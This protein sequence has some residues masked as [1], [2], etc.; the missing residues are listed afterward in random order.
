MWFDQSLVRAIRDAFPEWMAFFWALLSMLGSVWFVA[1]VVVLAFWFCDRHR[2]LSWVV[3]VLGGYAIMIGTKSYANIGRPDV[4]PAI[5]P[6]SLPSVIA[7]AY[8]P[9]VEVASSSFPSGHTIAGTIIWTMLALEI[10]F[11]TRRKRLAGAAVVIALIGVSRIALGLH[12]LG[13]VVAGFAIAGSYL[14]VVLTLPDWLERQT[15]LE[16]MTTTFALVTVVALLSL[17]GGRSDAA[18]VFGA[19]AGLWTVWTYAPPP[20]EPW[21]LFPSRVAQRIWSLSGVGLVVLVLAVLGSYGSW[22][23]VGYITGTLIGVVPRLSYSFM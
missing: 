14:L 6:E 19:V 22:L 13:D 17:F 9:F 3:T 20:R 8:A 21:P 16:S 11:G 5:A 7:F 15:G 23:L 4:G 18:G 2:F 10:R 1:P 12:Y